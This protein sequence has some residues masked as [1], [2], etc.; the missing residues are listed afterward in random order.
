MLASYQRCDLTEWAQSI[1]L[2]PDGQNPD[3]DILY[4]PLTSTKQSTPVLLPSYVAALEA[5]S[6]AFIR[7]DLRLI[8]HSQRTMYFALFIVV[9]NISVT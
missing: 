3:L 1:C 9:L 6:M 5:A 8:S 4:Q 7:C 2:S